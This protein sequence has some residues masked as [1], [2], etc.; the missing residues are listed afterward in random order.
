MAANSK[1][2]F[3]F[4]GSSRLNILTLWHNFDKTGLKFLFCNVIWALCIF[5]CQIGMS[6]S[7]L[8]SRLWRALRGSI[9]VKIRR[10]VGYG[11]GTRKQRI[12]IHI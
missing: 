6:A 2:D 5:G 10:G 12:I 3:E 8:F 9:A 7:P 1:L 11:W 4:D